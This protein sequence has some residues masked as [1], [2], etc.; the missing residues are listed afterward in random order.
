MAVQKRHST[1]GV[2]Y[3]GSA[4][5]AGDKLL[6]TCAMYFVVQLGVKSQTRGYMPRSTPTGQVDAG[7]W[8]EDLRSTVNEES[9]SLSMQNC[10]PH[11]L[12]WSI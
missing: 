1:N 2:R 10:R 5:L 7:L 11:V 9:K 6:G 8:W 4:C 12:A 3:R